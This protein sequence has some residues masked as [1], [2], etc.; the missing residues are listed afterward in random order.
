VGLRSRG[1]CSAQR[2]WHTGH[3]LHLG[4]GELLEVVCTREGTIGDKRGGT[5]SRVSR[6]HRRLDDLPKLWHITAMATEGWHQDRHASLVLDHELQ[7]HVIQVRPMISAVAAGEVHHLRLGLLL[8]VITAVDVNARALE[9]HTGRGSSPTFG[10]G[11]GH[12]AVE[13]RHPIVIEGVHGPTERI[14]MALGGDHAGRHEAGGGLMLE[15]PGDEV[16]RLMD[17]SQAIAHQ[18]FARFPDGEVAQFRVL[19]G[20]IIHDIAHG[21]FVTHA[22][23]EAEVIEGVTAVG[24]FPKFSSQEEIRPTPR[25]TQIPSR[26]CGMSVL[27]HRSCVTPDGREI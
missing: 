7:H 19:W 23:D 27:P 8:T 2:R 5:I 11:G 1:L 17:T 4:F 13:C 3:P 20:R 9:R 6:R 21:K 16:E 24:L 10:R 26:V 15:A 12:E 22:R 14:I 18:G 25:I